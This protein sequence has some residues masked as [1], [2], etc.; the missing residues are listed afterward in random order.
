MRI[1]GAAPDY[2]ADQGRFRPRL[3][4]V[5]RA[6]QN[7]PCSPERAHWPR[8]KSARSPSAGS[9]LH[10]GRQRHGRGYRRAVARGL[11][12]GEHWDAACQ[13]YPGRGQVRIPGRQ[14][15]PRVRGARGRPGRRRGHATA[16][17]PRNEKTGEHRRP[18][19]RV[20]D[21]Q[22]PAPLR[23]VSCQWGVDARDR[24][25][26]RRGGCIVDF[27]RSASA[28]PSPYRTL[29]LYRTGA[30]ALRRRGISFRFAARL[31][32]PESDPSGRQSARRIRRI[33]GVPDHGEP[34][35]EAA[36]GRPAVAAE[37]RTRAV[38]PAHMCRRMPAGTAI[39]ADR[40][41][42]AW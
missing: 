2:S 36:C 31:L 42:L 18:A 14:V 15:R 6:R 32:P 25:R 27:G 3:P 16:Q 9:G 1:I 33:R 24:L 4:D 26:Y 11:A 13:A 23:G 39:R 40:P 8:P 38:R 30:G 28:V 7:F 19:G 20:A 10:T 17:S 5:R 37:F 21:R 41:G 35:R 12:A 34:A 29:P 22:K